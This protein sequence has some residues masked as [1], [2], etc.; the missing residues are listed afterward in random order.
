MKSYP[1]PV[2]PPARQTIE[3]GIWTMALIVLAIAGPSLDGHLTLCIPTLLGFDG[4]W[5]CGLGRSIAYALRGNLAESWSYHVLGVPATLVLLNRII[6]LTFPS[7]TFVG[8]RHG[9]RIPST[10]RD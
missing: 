5:G 7:F 2:Q 8:R 3:A 6:T 1:H 10:A 4:C 9:K